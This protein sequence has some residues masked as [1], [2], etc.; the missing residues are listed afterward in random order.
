M[1]ERRASWGKMAS[2]AS[3]LQ[4]SIHRFSATERPVCLGTTRISSIASRRAS[5]NCTDPCDHIRDN[6]FWHVKAIPGKDLLG[7]I[8]A[9]CIPRRDRAECKCPKARWGGGGANSWNNTADGVL[10]KACKRGQ[11]ALM[12]PASRQSPPVAVYINNTKADHKIH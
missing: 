10:E 9:V 2:F 4:H 1:V 5:C 11:L 3:L 6:V 8:G 7:R 12:T